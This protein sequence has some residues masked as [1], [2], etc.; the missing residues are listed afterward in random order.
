[1]E[2]LKILPVVCLC[3]FQMLESISMW[4]HLL[5]IAGQLPFIGDLK[6]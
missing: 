6:K 4:F 2:L 1:M 3:V 5:L